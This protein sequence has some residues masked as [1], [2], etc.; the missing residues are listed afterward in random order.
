MRGWR[1]L[2]CENSQRCSHG[3]FQTAQSSA[4]GSEGRRGHRPSCPGWRCSDPGAE[5]LADEG[6]PTGQGLARTTA[7][8]EPCHSA[9]WPVLSAPWPGSRSCTC[10]CVCVH[11]C[12]GVVLFF[13]WDKPRTLV[14]ELENVSR[15]MTREC[16]VSVSLPVSKFGLSS[17][18]PASPVFPAGLYPEARVRDSTPPGTHLPPPSTRI[19]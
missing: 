16:V 3:G 14:P 5:W 15:R 4:L 7:P 19:R 13:A 11:A 2:V 6:P 10:V 18:S 8:G 1:R 12:G 9:F 17:F